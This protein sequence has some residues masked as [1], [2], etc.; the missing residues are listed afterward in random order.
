MQELPI[1]T[2]TINKSIDIIDES[3]KETRK[4]LDKISAKGIHKLSQLFWAS[5]LGVKAD[6]YIQERPYKLKKALEEMQAKYDL[7]PTEYQVEPSSYIAL[8]GVNEL[9]YS[10]EEDYIKEMFQNL[11]IADMDSR[12][13]NKVLPAYIEIIKQLSIEDASFL[14]NFNNA[15]TTFF[16]LILV[17]Y[18]IAP[19]P[20][21]KEL[22]ISKDKII[23]LKDI[24]VDNLERLNII[25][26]YDDKFLTDTQQY[27][28]G[29]KLIQDKYINPG[30]FQLGLTYK[31]ALLMITDFGKNFI[32]IC[33]S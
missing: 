21:G 3:T 24:V 2:D 15:K 23:T 12:K 7:I 30:P 25:K 22:I 14:Q 28:I 11:L 18:D 33:L 5:P 31:K 29:F 19:N 20:I 13:Q 27:D 4:E 6:V 17:N 26:V 8:K 9:N 16:G 1:N 10:L 32:D